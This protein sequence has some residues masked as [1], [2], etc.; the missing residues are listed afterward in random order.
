[1]HRPRHYINRLYARWKNDGRTYVPYS[2]RWLNQFAGALFWHNPGALIRPQYAWGIVFA[3]ALARALG[4]KDVA[5]IEFGVAGG[6]SLLAMQDIAREVSSAFDVG[7]HVYG[8]DTG[9][10]LPKLTDARDLPQLYRAGDYRMDFEALR[11][12]L[13][14]MTKLTIGDIRETIDG[15]LNTP[16]PP[17]GFVSFD[18]DT[19][20]ATRDS[21]KLFRDDF[22]SQCLPRVVCYFDDIMGATFGDLNGER[23][24]MREYT[25]QH[26]PRRAINPVYGLRYHV[27]WPHSTAQ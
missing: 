7:I 27:G 26:E 8:F 10:G 25:L 22:I 4:R 24:A 18:M 13:G 15:F 5:V 19:W 16:H 2:W 14:P 6:R 11:K 3:A 23:L 20:T 9:I 12:R 1:M 17:V 21:L